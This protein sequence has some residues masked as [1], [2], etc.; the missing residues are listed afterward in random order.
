M[1]HPLYHYFRRWR[2]EKALG[3]VSIEL[4]ENA[5][6]LRACL[7]RDP[8][9]SAGVVDSQSVKSTGVGGEDRGYDGGKKIKGLKSVT[10]SGGHR[11]GLVLK[12][13]VHSAKVMDFERGSRRCCIEQRSDSLASLSCGWTPDTVAKTRAMIGH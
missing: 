12:A 7:K 5:E 2:L 6:R 4:S 9:P 1:A 8:Q 10:S 13:K 11:E 3:S